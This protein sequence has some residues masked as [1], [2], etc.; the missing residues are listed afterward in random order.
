MKHLTEPQ[1]YKI[2]AFIEAGLNKT[3]IAQKLNVHKSTIT[4]EIQRN[5]YGR[6]RNYKPRIAQERAQYRWLHRKL[7]RRFKESV[8]ETARELLEKGFSPEQIVGYCRRHGIEM[9]SHETL[10]RWIWWD[11]KHKGGLHKFLRQRGRRHTKRGTSRKRRGIIQ[12]RIDI[13]ERPVIVNERSRFGDV[14]IDTIVGANH[15]QH[16]LTIVDRAAGVG[17]LRRLKK[18]TAE[19]TANQLIDILK[20]LA[21]IGLVKTITSDNGLQFAE[22][23]KVARH[24]KAGF[25]FARP[26]H[27]WERGSNENFNGLVRQYIPKGTD[28]DE[29]TDAFLEEVEQALNNRPRKRYGFLT[30]LERFS[31]VTGLPASRIF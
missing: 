29:V 15:G 13:S 8:K 23:E 18:G 24:L 16:I 27:S 10:Y 26:Y 30:P 4:R 3:Q 7:P 5:G 2:S 19:E 17:F 28:F 6:Y 22:H 21:R 1:R 14:E 20:D 25:Y 12:N 9:V 31:E 11:K